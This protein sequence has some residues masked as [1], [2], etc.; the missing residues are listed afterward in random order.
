MPFV[1]TTERPGTLAIHELLERFANDLWLPAHLSDEQKVGYI[2]FHFREQIAVELANVK[3][4]R[5]PT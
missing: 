2:L 1:V 4:G 3:I 5:R